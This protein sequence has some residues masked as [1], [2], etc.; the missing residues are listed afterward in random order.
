MRL[1]FKFATC[2]AV[3]A[4][5]SF[6]TNDS[7]HA[8]Q[9]ERAG[10]LGFELLP[11][12]GTGIDPLTAQNV[13]GFNGA[14]TTG[15]GTSSA[16][17]FAGAN[18]AEI[19]ISSTPN[20]F[21]GLQHA[22]TANAGD[23]FNFSFYG[24]DGPGLFDVGIEYRLEYFDAAGGEISRDQLTATTFGSSY[25]LFSVGGTAPTGTDSV[26][27]VIALQSF[28]GGTTGTAQIDNFSVIGPEVVPE[29]TSLGLL[30]LAAFGLVARRRRS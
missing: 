29:P 8:Q 7:V 27:A 24:V 23:V 18:H 19:V 26:R 12:G 13:F 22:F 5:M 14:G 20:T 17:P 1:F 10:N 30:G 11:I 25:S 2:F 9:V 15:F 21:A 6:M 4:A 3:V 16:N 28:Q